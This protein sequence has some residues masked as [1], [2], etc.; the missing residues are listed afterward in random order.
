MRTDPARP[1]RLALI[2]AAWLA[3]LAAGACKGRTNTMDTGRVGN[4]P[5]ADTGATGM[6]APADTAA[7]AKAPL[8]DAN[9]VFLLDEA[10][11]ADS[12]AGAFALGKASDK[13][14][15]DF[16]KMMMGE[17]HAL[18]VEGLA[19]AKKLKL[20]PEAPAEDPVKTAGSSEMAALQSA[21]SGAAFDK[22]YI[23][24]EVT[25]HKAVIDLAQKSYDQTQ[26]AELKALIEKAKPVL[27]KHLDRAEALQK[28]LGKTTT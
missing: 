24:Q 20:T 21:G 4:P 25:I 27:Q 15:K 5:P 13:G 26:N 14:V 1:A 18:R 7:A 19:L 12:S 10:N 3:V 9:I 2:G 8:S 28:Q 17:H 22:A 11:K 16:A 23:D 6:A